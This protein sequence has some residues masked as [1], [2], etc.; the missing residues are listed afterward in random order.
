MKQNDLA[1]SKGLDAGPWIYIIS[2]DYD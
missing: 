1:D 2:V